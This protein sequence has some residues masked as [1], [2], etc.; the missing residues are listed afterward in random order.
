MKKSYCMYRTYF[1]FFLRTGSLF[2][3]LFLPFIITCEVCLSFSNAEVKSIFAERE[4]TSLWI[5]EVINDLAVGLKGISKE[6]IFVIFQVWIRCIE[7]W[8]HGIFFICPEGNTHYTYSF[9]EDIVFHRISFP[10][11]FFTDSV[12]LIFVK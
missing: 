12:I 4:N 6:F 7:E 1:F 2:S 9:E 10:I 3:Y 11:D 5:L 8:L